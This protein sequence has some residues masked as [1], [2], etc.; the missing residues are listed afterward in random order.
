VAA[1]VAFAAGAAGLAIRVRDRK[2][3]GEVVKK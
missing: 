1:I 3:T 2:H